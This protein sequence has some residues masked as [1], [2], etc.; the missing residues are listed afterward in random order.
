[1]RSGCPATSASAAA[2]IRRSRRCYVSGV[3]Y[4]HVRG[5]SLQRG[6]NLNAAVDGVRPDPE[7]VNVVQVTSDARSSLDTINVNVDGGLSPP[8][9]PFLSNA[10]PL[11][12]WKRLRF[13][14]NYTLGWSHNNTEGDFAFPAGDL[15][16]EWGYAPQ[17]VRNRFNVGMNNQIVRNLTS[18]ITLNMASGT[19]YTLRTGLDDNGDLAFND[20]PPGVARNTARAASQMT[21][22]ANASYAIPFGRR[23][24]PPPPGFLISVVGNQ[25]PTV[26]QITTDWRYRLQFFVQ[27]QNLTN[28]A[29]YIGYSG[30]FTSPFFAQPTAV[31]N[32][33][34]VDIGMNF[35]F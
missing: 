22:N 19:P 30:V 24:T 18:G 7:F 2:W 33:R 6:L 17:D 15:A 5:T 10:S 16:Q 27:V 1:M 20:R 21:I 9:N 32:P 29:N 8:S 11:V 4:A 28:R 25:A 12:D 26:Q 3:T 34:K 31:A 14:G 35:Q 23:N 13:F